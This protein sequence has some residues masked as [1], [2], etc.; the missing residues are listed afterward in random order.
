MH[1]PFRPPC[2]AG[3]IAGERSRPSKVRPGGVLAAA[4]M[5]SSLAFIDGSALGVALPA[6]QS[7]LGADAAQAQWIANAYLLT[8]GAFVLVGGAAGDRLGRRRVFAVGVVLF[9]VASIV[10][11]L[12]PDAD[13]LIWARGVQGIGAA[14]LTPAS[15]ALIGA[16]FPKEE[17]GRAFGLWAGFGALAGM[18]GPLIGGGLADF[19]SW[20]V[21]FWINLPLAAAALILAF[22]FTPE[23]RD[24]E[25][26]GLDLIG[27]GLAVGALA[28]LTWGLTVLPERGATA[29]TLA[30]LAGGAVL[31]AAFVVHERRAAHP[32]TP[33]SLFASRVFS[34]VNVLTF[35]LYFA[36]GGVMFFLPFDLIRSHGFSASA[37]G[38]ALLPFAAIMGLFSGQAGRIADRFGARLSLSLG[39]LLAALGFVLLA[40]PAPGAGFVDGPLAGVTVLAIGMTLVVGP[41]TATVMGAVSDGQAGVAS[42]VNNAVARVAGLVAV[43]S[44]GGVLSL[45]HT[46][47]ASAAPVSDVMSGAVTDP[48]AVA[49]FHN[50]IRAVLVVCAAA[51]ALAGAVGAWSL[52]GQRAA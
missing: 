7:D 25:A 50:G 1:G 37:A 38:A 14:L 13:A 3:V 19:A 18:A 2:E 29:P 47:G 4:V 10:C 15:L 21:I 20:R 35:L 52:K 45:G 34:G 31:A 5:G 27:A 8:L 33:P 51:A 9:A 44:L 23:S 32:M 43:A 26:K 16:N 28:A 39:P 40:V 17:R 48:A 30:A 46:L 22:V 12:A 49:A 6:I 41:L 11:A 42:G 24:P 36:L